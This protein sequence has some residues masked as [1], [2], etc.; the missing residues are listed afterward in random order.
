MGIVDTYE[1]CFWLRADSADCPL[2]P[3]GVVRSY[4]SVEQGMLPLSFDSFFGP[5]LSSPLRAG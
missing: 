4:Q 2:K 5:V 3:R 1:V